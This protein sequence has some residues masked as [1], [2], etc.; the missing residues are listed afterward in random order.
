MEE[1]IDEGEEIYD[2]VR[3]AAGS[4]AKP[5]QGPWRN[6]HEEMEEEISLLPF[7]TRDPNQR[8]KG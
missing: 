3:T 1:D 4:I 7:C 2:E 8:E 5:P 6:S